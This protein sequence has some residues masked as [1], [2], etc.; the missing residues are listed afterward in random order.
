M[1]AKNSPPAADSREEF[2]LLPIYLQDILHEADLLLQERGTDNR[3][4]ID[5]LQRLEQE[6]KR[7]AGEKELV[8][9]YSREL[10]G[11][12]ESQPPLDYEDK[13]SQIPGVKAIF[14]KLDTYIQESR[15]NS[16]KVPHCL[17][18]LEQELKAFFELE[19]Y[20]IADYSQKLV[21][22][23]SAFDYR[24]EFSQFPPAVREI[25]HDMEVQLQEAF[26]DNKNLIQNQQSLD[27][28]R[29]RLAIFN[30]Q[31][32]E[33]I[34]ET[35][36]YSQ[37]IIEERRCIEE[38]NALIKQS[39]LSGHDSLR[40]QAI[41]DREIRQILDRKESYPSDAMN[42][43]KREMAARAEAEKQK[44]L[45]DRS[46]HSLKIAQAEV[47][48]LEERLELLAQK[49]AADQGGLFFRIVVSDNV[50]SSL[51]SSSSSSPS[52]LF[53]R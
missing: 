26:E 10:I 8:A 5:C 23:A 29:K 3:R 47:A 12:I 16:K 15:E 42:R 27:K 24:R 22:A 9:E 44:E 43:I 39:N 37:I 50:S 36:R 4:V 20:F 34:L 19:N 30:Q 46:A 13:F 31:Q 53:R 33:L 41:R 49:L 11:I 45:R 2:E 25:F 28:E 52:V 48:E 32:E 38:L 35:T 14:L 40:I 21:E 51:S 6:R 17:Q 7:L 18:L 1:S